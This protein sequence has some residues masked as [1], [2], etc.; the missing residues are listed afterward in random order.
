MA[1]HVPIYS[2]SLHAW[3]RTVVEESPEELVLHA[4]CVWKL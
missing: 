3:V 4:N 2:V 1:G